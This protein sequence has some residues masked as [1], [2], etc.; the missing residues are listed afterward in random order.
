M[1]LS[2]TQSY[3]IRSTG[4]TCESWIVWGL[5]L[6]GCCC[7]SVLFF[8]KSF[9]YNVWGVAVAVFCLFVFCLFF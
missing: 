5:L 1:C 7:C 3:G 8:N 9:C 6:G 4:P 2:L